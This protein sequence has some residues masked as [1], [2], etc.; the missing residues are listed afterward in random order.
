MEIYYLQKLFEKYILNECTNEEKRQLMAFIEQPENEDAVKNMIDDY[1]ARSHGEEELN[2]EKAS[3]IMRRIF[4]RGDNTAISLPHRKNR[5]FFLWRVAAVILFAVVGVYSW[6]YYQG[7]KQHL[8]DSTTA[9]T[10]AKPAVVPGGNYATLKRS[11][12]TVFLL[13]SLKDGSISQGNTRIEKKNGMLI[14]SVAEDKNLRADQIIYNTLSTPA[15]GQYQVLLPDGSKV[16]LNAASSLYFPSAF[17]SDIREVSIQGEAYF[18][19]AHDNRRPFHV[20][21]EDMVVKVLGTH[22]NINAYKDDDNIRT[23][24]LE[25]SIRITTGNTSKL[26][27]PGQQGILKT[28]NGALDVKDAD[29]DH[30]IAWKNGLFDFSGSDFYTIMHQISRWYNVD[31]EFAGQVPNRDFEGKISRK[32]QLSE[33]LQ[34]LELQ[35]LKFEVTGGKI[36]VKN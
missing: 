17:K 23:S 14:Y 18:E 4:Q 20:K 34:I 33:I 2:S 10:E 19:V 12:G 30:V 32:A 5:L 6:K 3:L 26:L 27:Q 9:K 8:E 35:N 7:D 36:I 16:W 29:M 25:G 11:N 15:G 24:L 21:V 13:D 31:I 22:F 1:I 28:G